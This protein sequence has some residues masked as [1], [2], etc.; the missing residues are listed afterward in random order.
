M[1][2]RKCKP[3]LWPVCKNEVNLP[4]GEVGVLIDV[5][6]DLNL[7]GIFDAQI[8]TSFSAFQR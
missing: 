1:S 2:Q 8:Q 4:A 7:G 6:P 3:V 5:C